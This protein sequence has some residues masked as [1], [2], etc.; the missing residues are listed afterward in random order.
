MR[1]HVSTGSAF[2][3]SFGYSRAVVVDDCVYVSGTTG[4]DYATMTLRG[5]AAAQARQ[6][7][8][9]IEQALS[10]VGSSLS[11]VVRVRY[12][13]SSREHWPAVGQV[14]GEVFASIRPAAT[15]IVAGLIEEA[16]HV[17]IEVEARLNP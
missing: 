3:A 16:M 9:N 14:A 4:Y 5:D 1:R 12:Y 17:E 11:D 8:S 10:Q 7:F 6:A 2:E 15:A 13:V